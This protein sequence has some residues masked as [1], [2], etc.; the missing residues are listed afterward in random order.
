ME[1]YCGPHRICR[2]LGFIWLA[3]TSLA[4]PQGE[5][6]RSKAGQYMDDLERE[7]QFS[8]AILIAQDGEVRFSKG[9]GLAN[10]EHEVPN[11]VNT[12]FRLGSLTKQFTA[13]C[14]LVLQEEGKLNVHQTVS[15]GQS[16]CYRPQ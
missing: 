7:E 9:Y 16:R 15:D 8:G 5:K 1:S 6:W 10:R 11:S 14:V 3:A 12:K 2:L 4:A 13:M